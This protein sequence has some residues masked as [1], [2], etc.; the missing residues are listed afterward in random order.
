MSTP[1]RTEVD[2]ERG[3][4]TGSALAA[5]AA[6]LPHGCGGDELALPPDRGQVVGRRRQQDQP[7]HSRALEPRA[8]RRALAQPSL[9]QTREDA[10]PESRGIAPRRGVGFPGPAAAL[11]Q[12][13]MPGLGG[14]AAGVAT[15]D[16]GPAR[17][18][19]PH[20]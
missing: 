1:T 13:R 20:D 11:G 12:I 14:E 2:M 6:L 19:A 8:L 7:V 16:R 4:Y 17:P 5:T 9:A 3:H 18:E 10:Q 15:R